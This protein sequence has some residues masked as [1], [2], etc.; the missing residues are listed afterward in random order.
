MRRARRF[1]LRV[2]PDALLGVLKRADAFRRPER[3]A[4]LLEAARLAD[5][6]ID[7]ARVERARAAAA[8]VDASAIAPSAHG[9]DIGRLIDEARLRV[10]RELG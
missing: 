10:I 2:R 6:G 8:A 4:Q 1:I 5:R 7:T 9:A 3:F